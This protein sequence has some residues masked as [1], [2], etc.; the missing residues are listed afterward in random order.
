VPLSQS[1]KKLVTSF[2]AN[3]RRERMARGITQEKMAE[4]V[5]LNIRTIQKIERGDLNV[6]ITTAARLHRAL[7]CTWNALLPTE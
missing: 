6:L 4:M 2:G 7:G 3:L 5:D 1:Q